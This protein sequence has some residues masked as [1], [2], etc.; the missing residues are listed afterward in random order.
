MAPP[1]DRLGQ[2]QANSYFEDDDSYNIP[3]DDDEG[4]AQTEFFK[5]V[6]E[7]R[8]TCEKINDKIQEVQKIQN[9]ILSAPQVDKIKQA[10]LDDSMAEIKKLANSVRSRLKKMEQE[11]ETEEKVRGTTAEMRIRKTQHMTI[12]RRF[13]EVMTEYNR[14][15]VDYRERSK[16][17]IQ[18]QL[19]IAGTT[20]TD[21][22]LEEMLQGGGAR[23]T[24]HIHIEGNEDQLRQTIN[25]IEARHEMFMKL[26]GSIKELHE[27]F[28]DIAMLIENQGEMVNRIDAHV[29]SAVEYTTRATNDTKKALEYQSA[30]RRKKIM[31]LLC[32]IVGG[33]L[34][35][36]IGLKYIGLVG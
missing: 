7:V 25:D 20:A 19:E 8:G 2:L 11:T 17:K 31:I 9:E 13:V 34:G 16:G 10:T 14:I 4:G 28:I 12:S 30:A 35:S 27:M 5:E 24:G 26:E 21:E 3:I 1:K 22:E 18:R 15:Q 32:M 6:E 36:Y 23:L 29:E 33:S